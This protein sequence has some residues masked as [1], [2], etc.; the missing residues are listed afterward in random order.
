VEGCEYRLEEKQI[1][2]WLSHFGEVKSELSE[3]TRI[4]QFK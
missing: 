3:D 4:G 1:I 2:D